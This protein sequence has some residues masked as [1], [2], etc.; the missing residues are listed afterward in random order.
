[1]GM[2]IK[3]YLSTFSPRLANFSNNLDVNA[4][5]TSSQLLVE[6]DTEMR[7]TLRVDGLS[8]F[9]GGF[10]STNGTI[11][12]DLIVKRDLIVEGTVNFTKMTTEHLYVGESQYK[13]VNSSLSFDSNKHSRKFFWS[14]MENHN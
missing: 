4:K 8:T 5:L 10:T 14:S 9:R 3:K 7:D 1:M 12:Q 13:S 6:Q 2:V 11:D